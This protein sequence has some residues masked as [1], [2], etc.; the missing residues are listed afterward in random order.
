MCKHAVKILP[1]LIRYVPDQCKNEQML[2]KPILEND[3]T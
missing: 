3:E 1:L 2:D